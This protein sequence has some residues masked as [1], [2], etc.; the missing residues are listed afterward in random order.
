MKKRENSHIGQSGMVNKYV[1]R[2]IH[3]ELES[4]CISHY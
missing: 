4:C 1:S 2:A 3:I